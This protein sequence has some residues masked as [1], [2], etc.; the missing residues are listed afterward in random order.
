MIT[1][2]IFYIHVQIKKKLKQWWSRKS[3]WM[4]LKM[5]KAHTVHACVGLYQEMVTEPRVSDACCELLMANLLLWIF[6][7]F[8]NLLQSKYI[9]VSCIFSLTKKMQVKRWKFLHNVTIWDRI[10]YTNKNDANRAQSKVK[11]KKK[12]RQPQ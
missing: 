5:N 11:L 8:V 1:G 10:I 12:W 2:Y 6:F 9:L 3:V 7:L 4:K